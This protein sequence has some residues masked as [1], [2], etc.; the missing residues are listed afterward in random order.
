MVPANSP[1]GATDLPVEQMDMFPWERDALILRSPDAMNMSDIVREEST[2]SVEE[3]LAEA[4]Q[5][6]RLTLSRWLVRDARGPAMREALKK[7]LNGSLPLHER[8]KRMDIVLEPLIHEWVA[9]EQTSERKA[10]ALLR[11]DCISLDGNT[12]AEG[13]TWVS[14]AARCLIHAPTRHEG[15]DPIRVFTARLSDELLRYSTFRNEVLEGKVSAIRTPKGAVRIGD[16]LFMATR[17]KEATNVIMENLGFTGKAAIAFPEELLR[18]EGA[19]EEDAV[20][21]VEA[22]AE[23]VPESDDLPESWK[24]KGMQVGKPT[25]D[26]NAKYHAFAEGTGKDIGSWEELIKKRRKMLNLE[27]DKDRPFQWTTQDF[28]VIA[29]IKASNILFIRKKNGAVAIN[30]WVQP[31]SINGDV[32]KQYMIFWGN[33]ELL[34]TKAG[35]GRTSIFIYDMLP[36]DLK[37]ALDGASPIPEDEAKIVNGPVEEPEAA[38]EESSVVQDM[39]DAVVSVSDQAAATANELVAPILGT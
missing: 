25:A 8:R 20:E 26:V 5:Y 35:Q 3:Q 2:A 21:E 10:L 29:V 17:P 18:F 11:Q 36:S 1:L 7:L 23:I 31:P 38:V 39:V 33:R 19:E 22:E 27:G 12:C 9:V 34:V 32:T 24:E 15:S 37:K 4:Y 6:L 13:C 16:E 28:Y 14:E 30:K